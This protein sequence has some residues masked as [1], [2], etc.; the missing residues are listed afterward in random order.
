MTRQPPPSAASALGIF[1]LRQYISTAVPRDVVEAARL[2]GCS[3]QGVYWRIVLPIARPALAALAL[4]AFI[5]SWNDHLAQLT[6]LHDMPMYTAPLALSSLVG[7]GHVPLGPIFA[8]ASLST[9]PVLLVYA[10][11]ARKLFLSLSIDS[12]AGG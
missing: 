8:G 11:L 7:T 3:T 9:L 2:D 4:L 12:S 1:L 6:T 5:G 10:L